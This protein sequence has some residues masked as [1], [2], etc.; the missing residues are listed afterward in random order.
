MHTETCHR[1]RSGRRGWIGRR[2]T[3]GL[4][5]F[6]ATCCLAAVLA[7]ASANGIELKGQFTQGGLV[8]GTV[9]AGSEV[10]LDERQVRVTPDGQFVIGF[11]RD[12]KPTARL[13]VRLRDGARQTRELAVKPRRYAIERVDGLPQEQVT[14]PAEV[15]A[16]IRAEADLVAVI[17]RTETLETWFR[18]GWHWPAEGK[19]SGV[20]GSQRILNGEPRQP[21][22][23]LDIAGPVGTP[24][25]ASAAGRVSLAE[26]DLYFTGGT[27]IIDHGYGLSSTYSHLNSVEVRQGQ[28]LSPGERIGTIG[29]T[30]RASGPHLDWR[31]NWFEVRLDPQLLLPP[32]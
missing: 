20:Y 23:G 32:R 22:F 17:R 10:W 2:R 27:I 9:P 12:A 29:A 1:S 6:A 21:H 3:L 5:L 26:N 15:L 28:V 16:R 7:P 24:V 30:G 13:E 11:G 31:L 19:V 14:P 25:V 4:V 8:L 18:S